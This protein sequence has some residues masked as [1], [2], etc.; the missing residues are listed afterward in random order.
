[1][2]DDYDPYSPGQYAEQKVVREIIEINPTEIASYRMGA[3][4]L[5]RHRFDFRR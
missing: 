5:L 1:M 3:S 2:S 4:G